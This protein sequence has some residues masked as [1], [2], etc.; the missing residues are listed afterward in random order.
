MS[1]LACEGPRALVAEALL[2]VI[3]GPPA[4]PEIAREVLH[5]FPEPAQL[6]RASF[7]D[8]ARVPGL[9]PSRAAALEAAIELGRRALRRPWPRGKRLRSSRE[10]YR[11]LAPRLRD[12]RREVFHVVLL[13]GRNRKMGEVQVS[14]GSLSASIVHPREVFLP[15]IRAS[16]A[17]ILVVHNHPSGDARPSP[18]D[19]EVTWRLRRAG[20]LLGI[21]LLDH[22]IIGDT[23]YYSFADE[24]TMAETPAEEVAAGGSGYGLDRP[25]SR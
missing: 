19:R 5:R 12:L 4:G 2:A 8:L 13:D 25:K 18:E 3:I 11:A 9:D 21:R 22:V 23:T 7:D 1:A 6:R 24:G 15:A 17:A 14:E 16:A 10:V 20:H